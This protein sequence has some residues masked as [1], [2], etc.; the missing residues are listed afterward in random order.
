[1]INTAELGITGDLASRWWTVALR[2]VLALLFGVVALVHPGVTV[3]VLVT[4]FGVYALFD[5]ILAIAAAVRAAERHRKWWPFGLEGGAGI[6]I[7]TL[8]MTRPGITVVIFV[9]SIAWW[10]IITGVFE[11]IAA[12]QLRRVI[13]GEWMLGA[14]GILSVLFGCILF[15]FPM[16]GASSVV[17]VIGAY[18]L[19]FGALLLALAMRL[20]RVAPV[21]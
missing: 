6:C 19:V 1:M 18:S 9:L 5:G 12:V 16:A 17:W 13:A 2:G 11:I 10:A 20:R 14:S 21:P 3:L 4:F 7:G 15:V 8:T